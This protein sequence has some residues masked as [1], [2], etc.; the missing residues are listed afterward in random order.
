MAE[1]SPVKIA[2]NRRNAL[3]STG[4]RSQRGKQIVRRNA[5]THGLLSQEV[6][7][8]A[9]DGREN[10]SEYN[11]LITQLAAQLQP[12]GI[13][14][15]MLIEKIAVCYWRL[16]RTIKCETGETRKQLDSAN[17]M[18]IFRIADQFQHDKTLGLLGAGMDTLGRTH[19]G[20]QHLLDV[21]NDIRS[22]VD[23]AGHLGSDDIA[24]LMN[25]YGHEEGG[26]VNTLLIYNVM[27][28]ERESKDAERM[29]G[30][31]KP[32]DPEI[33]KTAMTDLIDREIARLKVLE[34]AVREKERLDF[35][36]ETLGNH[37][38]PKEIVDRLLRY[39][40]TI[41]RQLYRAI[42]QLERL[43]RARRGELIPPPINV[44]VSTNN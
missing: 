34:K 1:T 30:D 35:E 13:L 29:W 43:Q 42:D 4:P 2:S 25:V 5:L 44:Q 17:L 37:L 39:E 15:E 28:T 24:R 12:E 6:V 18:W 27:A 3:K 38:P 16:R 11:Q 8:Q 41:E 14:E 31:D 32:P 9:G 40:T 22:G 19:L 7:I 26:F 23:E 33:L 36:S 10:Q 21:L 20:I